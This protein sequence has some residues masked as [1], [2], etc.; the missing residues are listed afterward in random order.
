MKPIYFK[1]I[2]SLEKKSFIISQRRFSH[3]P[4]HKALRCKSKLDP[5]TLLLLFLD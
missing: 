3:F 2:S 5:L 1:W 4:P